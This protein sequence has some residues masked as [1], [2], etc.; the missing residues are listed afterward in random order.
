MICEFG[1]FK[2]VYDLLS[3]K[4]KGEI[5]KFIIGQLSDFID[6]SFK[7]IST[8]ELDYEF[9]FDGPEDVTLKISASVDTSIPDSVYSDAV[10][11]MK[12]ILDE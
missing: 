12:K 11:R 1:E 6:E 5:K 9:L 4:Q 7:N 8:D 2:R 3:K 10:E